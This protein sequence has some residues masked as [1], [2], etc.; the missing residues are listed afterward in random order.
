MSPL[1]TSQ[2]T[3]ACRAIPS[4]PYYQSGLKRSG[5]LSDR[6]CLGENG[7]QGRNRTTDTRI[8]SPLLYRLSY[9]GLKMSRLYASLSMVSRAENELFIAPPVIAPLC[10]L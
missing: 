9:L 2:A 7:A 6:L 8:F 1:L 5:G 10:L 3:P 4:R